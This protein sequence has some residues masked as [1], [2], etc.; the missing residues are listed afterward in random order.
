M[1][2]KIT[3]IYHPVESP[4]NE[5][6]KIADEMQEAISS[7]YRRRVIADERKLEAILKE[8]G[9]RKASDVAEEIFAEIE[10]SLVIGGFVDGK[11]YI[12]IRE[13]DYNH[14]KK[15]YAEGKK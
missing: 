5:M 2:Y 11:K 13:D 7:E 12:A 4:I 14:Y 9:W 6:R 15:K 1:E 8:N 10:T 3:K